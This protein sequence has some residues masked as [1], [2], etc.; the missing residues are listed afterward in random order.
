[1]A[2]P[3]RR[4]PASAAAL[5]TFSLGFLAGCASPDHQAI[6]LAGQRRMVPVEVDGGFFDLFTFAP[7]H[8]VPGAPLSVYIEGDGRAFLHRT[9]LSDDPTPRQPVALEL[10]VR[11]PASNVIYLAR[12]CQYGRAGGR[13]NC[14]PA[15]WSTARYAEEVVAATS[16]VIDHYVAAS[17]AGGVR[18]YG[19]SGGSAVALLVAARR[20]D[21]TEVTT[22]AGLLDIDAWTRMQGVTPLTGSLNP[23]DAADRLM[24]VAQT[25]LV[26]GD[27]DVVPVAVAESFL[28][29]FPADRRPRVAVIPGLDHRCCWAERWPG[30]LRHGIAGRESG[31]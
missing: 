4:C 28:R 23:A 11:D 30:L 14:H 27:D 17:A 9:R 10:A 16:R 15:Y 19:Y 18:L 6:A 13:R 29:R 22:I 7:P 1:M 2:R 8:W 26:G 12:P 21:V 25:H 20:S 24:N 5:L 3:V 31:R